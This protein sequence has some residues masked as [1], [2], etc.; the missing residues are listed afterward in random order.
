MLFLIGFLPDIDL[1][2]GKIELLRGLGFYH[3]G[4]T[5]TFAAALLVGFLLWAVLRDR[6][7]ALQGFAV[8][9]LHIL[10]DL[11]MVDTNPPIGFAPFYPLSSELFT[12][13]IIPGAE[14]G[15]FSVLASQLNF[16]IITLETFI[17]ASLYIT[18]L[19]VKKWIGE[20]H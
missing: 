8:Y 7:F 15:S 19:G 17:F 6:R 12:F 18:V 14:K 16:H 2:L 1:V 3:Q 9:S 13:G 20:R 11:F 10:A 5:H 4:I